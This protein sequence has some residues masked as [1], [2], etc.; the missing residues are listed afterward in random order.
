MKNRVHRLLLML[1]LLALTALLV[2][3]VAGQEAKILTT[4]VDTGDPHSIDPQRA[5]D[6]K[7][8]NLLNPLFPALVTLNE[9]TGAI[10]PGL[11]ESWDVS[12]DGLTYTFHLIQ[13]APWVHYNADTGAVEQV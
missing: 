12:E 4:A 3:P 5:I 9:E 13:E 7:D 10:S 2:N 8:W 6:T 1:T 11:A